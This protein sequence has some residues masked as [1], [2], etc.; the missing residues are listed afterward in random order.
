[1]ADPDSG[2]VDIKLRL[3]SSTGT[4]QSGIVRRLNNMLTKSGSPDPNTGF[5]GSGFKSGRR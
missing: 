1:V 4:I 5:A 2:L 3:R